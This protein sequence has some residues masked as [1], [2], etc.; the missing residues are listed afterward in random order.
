MD[1]AFLQAMH[2]D[3]RYCIR[4]ESRALKTYSPSSKEIERQWHLVDADGAILGRLASEVAV[5]LRGKHKATFSPYLDTGDHVVVV[6]AAKIVVTADKLEKKRYYRHSGYPGS[7]RERS[8]ASVLERDPRDAV[9]MAVRGM[10]P[11]NRLGRQ[12]I[13]K[14]HVYTGPDHGNVAQS[15]EPYELDDRSRRKSEDGL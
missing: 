2:P 8:L 1:F 11:K 7:I 5:L 15:P 14:L 3:H 10:L 9:V 13:K 12:L 6:N 4:V